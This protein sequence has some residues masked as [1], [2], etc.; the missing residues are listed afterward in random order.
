MSG[1]TDLELKLIEKFLE[2]K[3]KLNKKIENRVSKIKEEDP[4]YYELVN[5]F[6]YSDEEAEDIDIKHN[7][8][9][10]LFANLGR[11]LE[12]LSNTLLKNAKGGK[13][14]KIT[15]PADSPPEKFQIDCVV[16]SDNKA[17]EIKWRDATTDGDHVKKE[18]NKIS[19]IENLGYIPVRVM[20]Y[21]PKRKQAQRICDKVA[22]LYRSEGEAYI[23]DD[24][25][26]YIENYTS[27]DLRHF[28]INELPEIEKNPCQEEINN[29]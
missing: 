4:D 22:R 27:F 3:K 17:H 2:R 6:G 7:I 28:M 14:L 29:F 1:Y 13:E 16:D 19:A 24:A 15:N 18:E 5:L 23:G 11:L 26:E 21:R 20:F 25:W 10:F 8:G 9:R 12:E